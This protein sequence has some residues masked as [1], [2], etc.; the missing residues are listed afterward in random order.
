MVMGKGDEDGLGGDE[1]KRKFGAGGQETGAK[2]TVNGSSS[3][4]GEHVPV[5]GPT[6]TVPTVTSLGN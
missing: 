1:G 6:T 2:K 5:P 3:N 4:G